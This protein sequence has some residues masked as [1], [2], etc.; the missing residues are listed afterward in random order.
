[1]ETYC[2]FHPP[3]VR[4]RGGGG[5][6]GGGGGGEGGGG[7]GGGE[8]GDAGGGAAGT[9]V[10]GQKYKR[11]SPALPEQEKSSSGN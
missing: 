4:G 11:P 8:G 1:M 7:E 10:H 6:G 5:E 3:G 9:P 2:P